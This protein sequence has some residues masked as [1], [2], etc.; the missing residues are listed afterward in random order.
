MKNELKWFFEEARNTF[1]GAN[2]PIHETFRANPYYSLVRESIQNSLDARK[3]QTKPVEVH[4]EIININQVEH[5]QLFSL[6]AHIQSCLEFH[7]ADK[8]ANDLYSQMLKYINENSSIKIL[9]VSDYNTRGMHYEKDNYL[10]PF[11]SFMSEGISSK[12][13]GSGG[14]F[15]FGKGAYYVP[16]ELRTILVS[17][18]IEDGKFVFQGRTRLAS[19][20]IDGK[21]KGK[22]GV[23]KIEEEMPVTNPTEISAIFRRNVQGTDVFII[24]MKD[25]QHCGR[26][27]IKSVLNNFWYAVH[28]NL[29]DVVIKSEDVNIKVNETNLEE[30]IELY[31][32]E[33]VERGP[34][35]EIFQW[36]PKAYYKAV[37]YSQ[38]ADDFIL[39]NDSLP[40]IGSLKFYVYRK[41]GLQ[42]RI[43]FMRKPGMIVYKTGRSILS[44]YAAVFICDNEIGN[45]I[46]R[47][48]ENAAHNE[49]KPEN[50]R[51]IDQ[52][53]MQIYRDAYKQINEY[54]RE[55]LKSISGISNSSKI[56]VVGLSDFLSIP[57]ELLGE[58]EAV[59]GLADSTREG[60]MSNN[61]SKHETGL[62]TTLNT[63]IN[64]RTYP[65]PNHSVT[66][67]A[68]NHDDTDVLLKGGGETNKS[69][70]PNP[71]VSSDPGN[72]TDEG[73][74]DNTG[75]RREL[76]P[77]SFRV[78]ATKE[79]NNF[80][81]SL[82]IKSSENYS[83]VTIDIKGGTDNGEDT[84][85]DIIETDA[86]SIQQNQITG[87]NLTKGKNIIKVRF[88]DE[89]K[90]TLKVTAYEV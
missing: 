53:K 62:L 51:Y 41:D 6:R 70:N 44:G 76:I 47:Q 5:P 33:E 18:M 39:F 80:I 74:A 88:D 29:L 84:E 16:S 63:P 43:A 72:L 42:D 8:Q 54:I 89:I 50:V 28:S 82:I 12:L 90:H 1:S 31:F 22:D 35:G 55:K 15:G 3:D 38:Q 24:G 4:F 2:D 21:I 17:T 57:E 10:C 59:N 77:I 37:K 69:Q 11:I 56:D 60:K 78:A 45:E 13:S 86:G 49:W 32:P 20:K 46:L 85:L 64:V 58:E 52:D 26:E 65:P 71:I 66:V 34:V 68:E 81:H 19:H 40:A 23:F 36:N 87:V 30:I 7:A 61:I 75:E 48:M 27:M 9:K 83:G 25:D 14:S 67:S 79:K 73:R